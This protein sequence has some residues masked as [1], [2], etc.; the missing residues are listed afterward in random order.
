MKSSNAKFSK[1]ALLVNRFLYAIYDVWTFFL[2]VIDWLVD[3]SFGRPLYSI[4]FIRKKINE[5]EG[6]DNYISLRRKWKI[7]K[8]AF[9]YNK[10]SIFIFILPLFLFLNVATIIIGNPL[11]LL[12]TKNVVWCVVLLISII[13]LPSF[14]LDEYF[15]WRKDRY[16]TFFS[17]FKKEHLIKRI[18]WVV[19]TFAMLILLLVVNVKLFCYIMEIA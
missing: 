18:A 17:I 1:I 12:Y 9:C 5:R 2:W 11:K 7:P 4:P 14:I 13:M 10:L 15:F 8:S 6:V 19:G 16:L 3:W